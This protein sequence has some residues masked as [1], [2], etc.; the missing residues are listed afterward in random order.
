MTLSSRLKA[1]SKSATMLPS[2]LNSIKVQ[3]DDEHRPQDPQESAV[4]QDR[5]EEGAQEDG[6]VVVGDLALEVVGVAVGVEQDEQDE[7]DAGPRHEALH[8]DGR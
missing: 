7:H 2:H 5:H 4:G 3:Q 6:V 1:V 8:E